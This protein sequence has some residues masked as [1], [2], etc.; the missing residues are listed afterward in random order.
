[1]GFKQRE[2][3]MTLKNLKQ[4]RYSRFIMGVIAKLPLL[5]STLLLMLPNIGE[6][7]GFTTPLRG[8]FGSFA[9]RRGWIESAQVGVGGGGVGPLYMAAGC[10]PRS[11]A[12]GFHQG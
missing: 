5:I 7:F 8:T 6:A 12:T 1:V 3:T 10:A 4:G 11:P 9:V 2:A